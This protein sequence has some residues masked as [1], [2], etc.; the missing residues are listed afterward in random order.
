MKYDKNNL[1]LFMVNSYN[2]QLVKVNG[3]K[4]KSTKTDARN[5][6]IGLSSVNRAAAKYHGTVIVEDSVAEQFKIR[7]LLYGS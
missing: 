6:G 7:V 2:G 5:H 4:L 1:L 3:N